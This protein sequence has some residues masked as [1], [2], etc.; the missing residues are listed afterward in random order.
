MIKPGEILTPED[1]NILLDVR[2]VMSF[3]LGKETHKESLLKA[4]IKLSE[5]FP[6]E[7]RQQPLH[8]YISQARLPKIN[9]ESLE[10]L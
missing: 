7:H 2:N 1:F 10:D 5:T 9:T 6:M 8:P 3:G 4:F